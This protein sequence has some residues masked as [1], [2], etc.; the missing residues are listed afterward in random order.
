[1]SF[2]TLYIII[3]YRLM[4]L[5]QMMNEILEFFLIVIVK[6]ESEVPMSKVQKSNPLDSTSQKKL[7]ERRRVAGYQE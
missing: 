3:S 6:P 2:I 4:D 7:K 5:E 1:M